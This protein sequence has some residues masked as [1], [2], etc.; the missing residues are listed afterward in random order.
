MVNDPKAVGRI[1][2]ERGTGQ[3]YAAT[4]QNLMCYPVAFA[5]LAE[6]ADAPDS[7]SGGRKAV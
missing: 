3:K 5:G 6:L 2:L 1:S 7:K 4:S